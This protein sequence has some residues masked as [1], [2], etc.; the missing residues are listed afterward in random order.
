MID[1]YGSPNGRF[2]SPVGTP[3]EMRG[4]PSS[5]IGDDYTVYEV[6]RRLPV[7]TGLIAPWMDSAGFG[8]QHWLPAGAQ[9][10][11]DAGYLRV[12]GQ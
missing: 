4:L 7:R 1:R 2:T 6:T 5:R 8:I 11:V 10:L 3:F 12:V 9:D